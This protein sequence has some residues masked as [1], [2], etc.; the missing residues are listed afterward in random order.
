MAKTVSDQSICKSCYSSI[1]GMRHKPCSTRNVV[2]PSLLVVTNR[3][4]VREYLAL[5][6]RVSFVRTESVRSASAKSDSIP[7][8]SIEEDED[9][10][11]E[12]G[13][14]SRVT[15]DRICSAANIL[16]S[17]GDY[18]VEQHL[19]YLL[20]IRTANAE[21]MTY[22]EHP[23]LLLTK[24]KVRK[25][26]SSSSYKREAAF[27][28]YCSKYKENCPELKIPQNTIVGEDHRYFCS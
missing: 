16:I 5:R 23:K 14:V 12:E 10:M 20:L 13:L 2:T 15:V 17:T 6:K 24:D 26:P 22:E 18:A 7:K 8:R 19:N 25:T 3:E 28:E 1:G 11:E 4:E 9:K 27:S 21:E